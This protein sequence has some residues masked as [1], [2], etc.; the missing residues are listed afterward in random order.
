MI[1]LLVDL[2]M[3]L[4]S[5]T[6]DNSVSDNQIRR[7]T[8]IASLPI[9]SYL[10]KYITKY[11]FVVGGFFRLRYVLRLRIKAKLYVLAIQS[12]HFDD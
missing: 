8:R 5:A 7:V 11:F 4:K 2:K 3:I 10:L 1:G 12:G 6:M 9:D